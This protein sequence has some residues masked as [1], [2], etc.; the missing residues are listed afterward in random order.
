MINTNRTLVLFDFD[1][2]KLWSAVTTGV[3]S[4][5][6]NLLHYKIPKSQFSTFNLK[7]TV[8][9]FTISSEIKGGRTLFY[10][11]KPKDLELTKPNIQIKKI[12]DLT[13]EVS[14]DVLAK[15]VYL[16][17]EQE[18]FFNDNYF[19][20]LPNQKVEIKLS[21]SVQKIEVKSLFD[22]LN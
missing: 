4:G 21:K 13:Y 18:T 11:A 12:D 7:N 20:I 10:F 17:S 16:S 3:I 22:T 5:S 1:G 14:S 9:S 2:K 6:S 15:N 19:D 8:L